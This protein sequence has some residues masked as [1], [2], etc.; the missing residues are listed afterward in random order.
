MLTLGVPCFRRYDLLQRLLESAERGTVKPDRYMVIDNGSQLRQKIAG[1]EIVLPPSAEVHNFNRNIG[2]SA[3]WNK[4]LTGSPDWVVISN[5]DVEF[6]PD[7]LEKLVRAA[8]T[9][10]AEYL[11]P[12]SAGSMFC[13]FLV[14]QSG[15]AKI[16]P[17]DENF[18]PAYFEDNDY[19]RR[20][21]LLNIHELQVPDAGYLHV[22]SA[23]LKSLSPEELAIHHHQFDVNRDYYYRKWGGNPGSETLTTP[24]AVSRR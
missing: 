19:H 12:G 11:F 4:I 1:G 2:V 21:K 10:E 6:A 3:A 13:V 20:M 16:G 24:A 5:D 9:S 14:K 8:E 22:G 23:Y 15:Y 7:M 17:F 18:F